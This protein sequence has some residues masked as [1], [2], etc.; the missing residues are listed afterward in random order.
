[1][2]LKRAKV[3]KMVA[4]GNNEA[5]WLS[6]VLELTQLDTEPEQKLSTEVKRVRITELA[7]AEADWK[8]VAAA[9]SEATSPMPSK[10]APAPITGA[11]DGPLAALLAAPASLDKSLSDDPLV[12]VFGTEDK[13]SAFG[14]AASHAL[15]GGWKTLK[16]S[17]EGKP[18][19][20]HGKT[21]GY[22]LANVNW[23]R[24]GK[25]FPLRMSAMLIAVAGADGSFAVV[26]VHYAAQ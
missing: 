1:L 15:L 19:E 22:A 24:P 11:T 4:G 14:P 6:A 20:V 17:L 18:R 25:P 12:A 21:W 9:A 2:T 8:V 26:A 3:A 5:A 10:E 7:T 16:L 13:E 23:Q